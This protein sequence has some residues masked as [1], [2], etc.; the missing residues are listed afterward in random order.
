MYS[1]KRKGSCLKLAAQVFVKENALSKSV[2]ILLIFKYFPF[3]HLQ[4]S[5][6]Q[7]KISSFVFFCFVVVE[8]LVCLWGFFVWFSFG[9]GVSLL[10]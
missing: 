6:V 8:I 4:E 5:E 9:F 10:F 1:K 7:C 3:S 2:I